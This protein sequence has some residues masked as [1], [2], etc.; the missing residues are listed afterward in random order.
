MHHNRVH[1]VWVVTRV[2][3]ASSNHI[4]RMWVEGSLEAARTRVNKRNLYF[5]KSHYQLHHGFVVLEKL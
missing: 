1:N 4:R 3:K 2:D 5:V